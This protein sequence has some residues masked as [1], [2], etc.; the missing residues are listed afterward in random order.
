MNDSH[1][2][3]EEADNTYLREEL[4]CRLGAQ[5]KKVREEKSL[6]IPEVAQSLKLRQIYLAALESGNWDE[7]PGE[8]YA[9]GF[10]K[11]YAAFLSVDVSDEIAKLKSEEYQLTKPLT[12]PDPAIAPRKSWV[13]VAA[14]VFV[15]LFILFNMIGSDTPEQSGTILPPPVEQQME[16][17]LPAEAPEEAVEP[18]DAMQAQSAPQ[19]A[20]A[21]LHTYRFT[22]VD[23]ECW[24]QVSL[25]VAGDEEIPELIEEVLLKP[26]ETLKLEHDAPYLLVTTGNAAALQVSIDDKTVAEAGSLGKENKVIRNRKFQPAE[27]SAAE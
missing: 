21:A 5:L 10:L 14:L 20:T 17:M 7:M 19:E 4:L 16:E 23:S 2:P 3:A 1:S 18:S 24:I 27:S 15:V 12:F 22:A 26:G 25:P 11:Q 6:S 9:I 8:V 13:I